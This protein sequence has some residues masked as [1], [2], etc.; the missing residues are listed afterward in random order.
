MCI[1]KYKN[2][3]LEKYK[4]QQQQCLLPG[5]VVALDWSMKTHHLTNQIVSLELCST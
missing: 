1:T 3:Y 5:M 2:K 4:L